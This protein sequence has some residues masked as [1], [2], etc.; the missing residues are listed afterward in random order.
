MF[1]QS[2]DIPTLGGMAGVPAQLSL[3]E[4]LFLHMLFGWNGHI[5]VP[6]D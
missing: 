2:N 4:K 6:F 1:T 5:F 3:I